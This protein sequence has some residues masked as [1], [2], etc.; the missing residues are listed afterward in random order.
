ME[1]ICLRLISQ[2]HQHRNIL[3]C[4]QLGMQALR[5][6]NVGIFVHCKTIHSQCRPRSRHIELIKL[7]LVFF[8]H[9]KLEILRFV[10]GKHCFFASQTRLKKIMN[11]CL[12]MMKSIC[13]TSKKPNKKNY[14]QEHFPKRVFQIR[15]STTTASKRIF[16]SSGKH[17]FTL[18]IRKNIPVSLQMSLTQI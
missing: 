3:D 17:L 4:K 6:Q 1:H 18:S 5:I 7:V 9:K 16:K 13:L 10:T 2:S 15:S 11:F 8:L 14:F 12:K